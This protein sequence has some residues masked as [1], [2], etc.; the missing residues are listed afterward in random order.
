MTH[1]RLV[2]HAETAAVS[3]GGQFVLVAQFGAAPP[4]WAIDLFGQF[5]EPDKYTEPCTNTVAVVKQ[6]LINENN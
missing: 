2:H 1:G 3:T 4:N 5:S 6:T